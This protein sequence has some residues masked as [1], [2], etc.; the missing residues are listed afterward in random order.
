MNNRATSTSAEI[1]LSPLVCGDI[2]AF[3]GPFSTR[4]HTEDVEKLMKKSILLRALWLWNPIFSS[5]CLNSYAPVRIL[6][7]ADCGVLLLIVLFSGSCITHPLRIASPPKASV[8]RLPCSVDKSVNPLRQAFSR[9]PRPRVR[10]QP[11]H[12][13]RLLQLTATLYNV[14]G[15]RTVCPS[16]TTVFIFPRRCRDSKRAARNGFE[17][18]KTLEADWFYFYFLLS[19]PIRRIHGEKIRHFIYFIQKL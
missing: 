15:L 18:T 4:S 16:N 7:S 11:L 12:F 8:I 2:K 17:Q 9:E 3:R 6:I 1:I 13:L 5:F 19:H 14:R 10:S